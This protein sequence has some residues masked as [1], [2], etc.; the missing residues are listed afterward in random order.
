MHAP[1]TVL[2]LLRI[3]PRLHPIRL[4]DALQRPVQEGLHLHVDLSL[5]AAH[6]GYGD[7]A[8]NAQGRHRCIDLAGGDAIDV[9][10][11]H[12]SIEG[13]IHAASRLEGR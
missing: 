1:L 2:N 9:R 7:A 6:L 3:D 4:F 11:S 5:D 8:L 10:L 13:L 12:D